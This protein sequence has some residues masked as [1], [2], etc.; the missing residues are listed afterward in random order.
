MLQS[1]FFRICLGIILI[2]LIIY[3][4][5]MVSFIFQPIVS[6]FSLLIVPLSLSFFFYYLLRPLV[7]GLEKRFQMN[8]ALS[9]ILIY[10]TGAAVITGF[11]MWVWPTLL[12]QI[13]MF[14]TNA[15]K[16]MD[17]LQEQLINLQNTRLISGL[18]PDDSNLLN[19][20][21]GYLN[22]GYTL[23]GG[24]VAGLISFFSDLFIVL[25]TVPIVLYYM[26]K[27]G[28]K[29]GDIFTSILPRKFRGQ[30]IDTIHEID[31]A[32]SGY[33]VSRV[34]INVLLGILMYIGFLLIGLPYSLLFTIIAIILN[35]IPYVGAI[36]ASIPV[37][38]VA[39]L[40]SPYMALWAL[41]IIIA[42][43]QIQDNILTPVIF[44]KQM[45][46][47]PVT[48]VILLLVG[49]DL[50][51]ILGMLLCIPFYIVVKILVIRV[52]HLFFQEKVE[53]II[54]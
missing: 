25:A 9:V 8:R 52:Y 47:H 50:A 7:N 26:L 53:E 22:Q 3:L 31:V 27:E 16:F 37:L 32:L 46:I 14:A 18:L 12:E 19:Q 1:N 42:S 33:V 24:Y 34:F 40:E 6:L 45:E 49:G 39:F 43:Q 35:F 23:A 41:I 17:R 51:G 15:P 13:E 29:F 48:I 2:L 44:G 30:G 20:L 10:A 4:G 36:L 28:D 54:E 11:T 38:I 5:T 21:S